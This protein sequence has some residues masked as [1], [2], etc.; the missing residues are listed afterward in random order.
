MVAPTSDEK[1]PWG[2]MRCLADGPE[3]GL[4]LALMQLK[5]GATSPAHRHGNCNEVLHVLK[6]RISARIGEQ[7]VF[8]ASGETLT[9][10]EGVVHQIHNPA[11]VDAEMVIAYSSGERAYEELT[12]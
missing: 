9:I 3:A 4:S 7:W 11:D 6:G 12:E 1:T 8:L 10:D 2:A 5:A